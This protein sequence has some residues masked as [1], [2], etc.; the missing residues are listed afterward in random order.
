MKIGK[1]LF[2][3]MI[4]SSTSYAQV[5]LEGF[6]SGRYEVRKTKPTH[7]KPTSEG[8][9]ETKTETT[10]STAVAPGAAATTTMT[11]T[12]AT[13]T[14]VTE[15]SPTPTVVATTSAAVEAQE[16]SISEQAESLFSSKAEKV[17]DFYRVQVHPDDVRNN[18][19]ELEVMPVIGYT[20]SQ[21]NYSYRDYQSLFEALKIKTNVWFTPLIG[22]SGQLMFS[23]AADMDSVSGS[24]RVPT[25]YEYLDLGINF[26]RFF[27][28]SRLSNS[29]EFA[30]LYSDSKVNVE[31][32]N[33]SRPRLKTSGFGM[34]LKARVPTS[35]SYAW[36]FG[37]SFYP[38]L[39]HS[40]SE[41]G[42]DIKS[43]TSDENI[44]LGVDL[45][46]E[47]KFTRESQLIWNL[48][49]STEKNTFDG[50]ASLPDPHTSATPDNV[51]V[52]NSLIMFSLGYR[53]GH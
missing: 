31:S 6:S 39:Q 10:T 5:G 38:R 14:P 49:L 18:K 3:M 34:A 21:S 20:D 48:G 19:V 37:G 47:F 32:D 16:P 7:R 23:F 27:G 30:V 45:G 22:V 26:R 46:G 13:P 2:V 17:Y 42:V 33:T 28:V 41:T 36:T 29:M 24:S 15:A 50:A 25:K 51:S 53:W 44:R 52:T 43:G 35:E 9:A 40:E 11:T 12:V 1:I 4:V 8:P